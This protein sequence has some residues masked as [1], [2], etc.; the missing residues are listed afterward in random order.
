MCL[1]APNES[2]FV[3]P[4]ASAGHWR[5]VRPPR[6]LWTAARI[7]LHRAGCTGMRRCR[8]TD[9]NAAAARSPPGS[10]IAPVFQQHGQV[11][12]LASAHERWLETPPDCGIAAVHSRRTGRP[13]LRDRLVVARDDDRVAGLGL[14]D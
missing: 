2:D 4:R 12:A 1:L 11:P 8:H 10:P 6:F 3:W 5:A 7:R 14:S 9:A 13:Q